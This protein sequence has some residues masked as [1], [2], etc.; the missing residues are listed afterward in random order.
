MEPGGGVRVQLGWSWVPCSEDAAPTEA[1]MGLLSGDT[2]G[3]P[4]RNRAHLLA[5]AGP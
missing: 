4:G 1:A 3:A 5:L 2:R